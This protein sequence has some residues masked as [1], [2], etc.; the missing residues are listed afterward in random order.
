ML[1][2][3]LLLNTVGIGLF[4]WLIFTLAVFALP[5]F[6]AIN[7]GLW[8]CH[9]G[10]GLLGTPLVAVGAGG[11]T[12]AIAQI[13]FAMT[14]S[15]ILRAVIAAVFALPA[16]FAGYHVAL[17]MAQIGVPSPVWQE[18]FAC[19]GAVFVGGTAWTRLTVF[20]ETRPVEPGWAIDDSPQPVLAAATREG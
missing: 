10:A 1:A 16:A 20:R 6:V 9:S 4:C 5:F 7:V 14:Q 15:L 2:L 18:I 12:L 13:A 17:A 19:L 11:M 8:A 3:G